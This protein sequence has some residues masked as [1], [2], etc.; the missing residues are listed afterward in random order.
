MQ[1]PGITS[2]IGPDKSQ[3]GFRLLFRRLVWLLVV[4]WSVQ[5]TS[6]F[7]WCRAKGDAILFTFSYGCAKCASNQPRS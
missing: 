5:P 1:C 7:V 6:F 4:T 3:S 2:F